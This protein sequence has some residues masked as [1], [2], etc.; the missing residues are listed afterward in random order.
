MAE[1]RLLGII[2]R[3]MVSD[4]HVVSSGQ[5]VRARHVSLSGRVARAEMQCALQERFWFLP[6]AMTS[7]ES[8]RWRDAN[9][10]LTVV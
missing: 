5:E 4:D 6:S 1:S 10:K 8:L 2:Q 9:D 3:K 7:K